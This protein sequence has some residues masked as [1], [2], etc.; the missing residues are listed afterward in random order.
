MAANRLDPRSFD[1]D[2]LSENATFL[3]IEG[4]ANWQ[5]LVERLKTDKNEIDHA[6]RSRGRQDVIDTLTRRDQ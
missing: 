2:C 3:V 1:A 5:T 4:R 6:L